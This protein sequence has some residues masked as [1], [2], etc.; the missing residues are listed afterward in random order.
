MRPETRDQVHW[1]N[2][3]SAQR[4]SGLGEGQPETHQSGRSPDGLRT[5]SVHEVG[6]CQRLSLIC[7]VGYVPVGV[8]PGICFGDFL[9]SHCLQLSKILS[10]G[11]DFPFSGLPRLQRGL[12]PL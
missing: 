11:C 9:K 2:G 10:A 5:M 3:E 1:G 4:K 7:E 6:D 8:T 12:Q